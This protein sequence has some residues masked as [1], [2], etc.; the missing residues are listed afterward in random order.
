METKVRNWLLPAMISIMIIIAIYQG[1][2]SISA[3]EASSIQPTLNLTLCI[4]GETEACPPDGYK[5]Y[6]LEEDSNCPSLTPKNIEDWI[7]EKRAHQIVNIPPSEII[8]DIRFLE[9]LAT[10]QGDNPESKPPCER[11]SMVLMFEFKNLQ[12]DAVSIRRDTNK[13]YT[14]IPPRIWNGRL[15]NEKRLIYHERADAFFPA[16]NIRWTLRIGGKEWKIR[17]GG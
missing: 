4:V 7:F 12:E 9:A 1:F 16:Y 13:K 3:E 11:K 14:Q 6:Y 5:D 8:L 15:D 2:T 10:Y 17:T